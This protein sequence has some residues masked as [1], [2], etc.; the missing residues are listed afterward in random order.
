MAVDD[1]F[2]DR[3]LVYNKNNRGLKTDLWGMPDNTG[4]HDN[5]LQLNLGNV[6]LSCILSY[7]WKI[8]ITKVVCSNV[9]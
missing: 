5:G 6:I 3:P 4:D 1:R 9:M 7:T 8:S 2:L